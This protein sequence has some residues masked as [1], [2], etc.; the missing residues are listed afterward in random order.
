MDQQQRVLLTRHRVPQ[1]L[2]AD[3]HQL[4]QF[5]P[6]VSITSSPGLGETVTVPTDPRPG[7]TPDE[8]RAA[9]LRGPELDRP[10]VLT[11]LVAARYR[12][13]VPNPRP[14]ETDESRRAAAVLD[15]LLPADGSPEHQPESDFAYS[16]MLDARFISYSQPAGLS[17]HPPEDFTH[18]EALAAFAS[19]FISADALDACSERATVY[20]DDINRLQLEA[21]VTLAMI[22][23][24]IE[25]KS[26][27]DRRFS[28]DL[29]AALGTGWA[30]PQYGAPLSV[31]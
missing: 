11:E 22:F 10:T 30:S 14:P 21:L 26:A 5:L 4:R 27:R 8:A 28:E 13:A 16:T 2:R 18:R 17:D 23:E 9:L 6:S 7:L 25:A 19:A 29:H 15:L 24:E 31:N 12:L 1:I 3:A 20:F